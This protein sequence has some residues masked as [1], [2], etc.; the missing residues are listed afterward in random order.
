MN[1]Y[2]RGDVGDELLMMRYQ[3]GDRVAFQSLLRRHQRSVYNYLLLRGADAERAEAFAHE[4]FLTVV[5]RASEYTQES[6]FRSWLFGMVR[7]VQLSLQAS[8]RSQRER[9]RSSALELVTE[10]P[11]P[12][13]ERPE[14]LSHSSAIS[15]Q[16]VNVVQTLPD[17]QQEA[18]LLKELGG[19]TLKEV[20]DVMGLGEAA[21]GQHLR[22]AL[23]ALH[24]AL[25][26]FEEHSRGLR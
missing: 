4:V 12:K 10:R 24:K 15:A 17:P 18:L 22:A 19:L 11:E 2:A 6:R 5:R 14:R 20:A 8:N 13:P 16:V 25:S 3:R 7:G 26:G 9:A 23:E 21:A 1:A